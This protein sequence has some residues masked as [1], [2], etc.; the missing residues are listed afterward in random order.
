MTRST[1]GFYSQRYVFYP[2]G[3]RAL[4]AGYITARAK[5]PALSDDPARSLAN[6]ARGLS[7]ASQMTETVTPMRWKKRL[8]L[9]VCSSSG[10]EDAS[11]MRQEYRPPDNR[12][13]SV[14]LGGPNGHAQEC[15]F[16]A[17]RSR[18]DGPR[19]GGSRL[20]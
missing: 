7:S 20:I 15:A 6:G 19:A 12:Q 18:D 16:D 14:I 11:R 13:P 5:S 17:A 10:T 8:G 4:T 1:L 9:G 3:R 2:C